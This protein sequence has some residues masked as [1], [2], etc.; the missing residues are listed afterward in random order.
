MHAK[1]TW[2]NKDEDKDMQLSQWWTAMTP[3]DDDFGGLQLPVS[4]EF[5]VQN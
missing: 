4:A 5:L 3:V 2:V 1:W